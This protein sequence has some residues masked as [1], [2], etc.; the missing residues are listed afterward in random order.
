MDSHQLVVY[1]EGSRKVIREQKELSQCGAT[2]AE[3]DL[4]L[5]FRGSEHLSKCL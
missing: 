4:E 3:A 2:G 5:Y 1:K